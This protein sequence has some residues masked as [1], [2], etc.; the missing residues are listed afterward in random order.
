MKIAIFTERLLWLVGFSPA[1]PDF[2]LVA[3]NM[4]NHFLRREP[5]LT[6]II[7]ARDPK[8][9]GGKGDCTIILMMMFMMMLMMMMMVM[10]VMGMGME[11]MM[12][13]R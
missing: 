1:R 5:G 13:R 2:W 9:C 11:M 3:S 12:R 10:M 8:Q 4:L 7:L 6:N